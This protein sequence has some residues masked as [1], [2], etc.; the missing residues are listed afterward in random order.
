MKKTSFIFTAFMMALLLGACGGKKQAP[1]ADSAYDDWEE[2][3]IQ[4]RDSTVYGL[5]MD[6]S[7]MHSLQLLS[8]TGDTLMLDVMQAQENG[9]VYGGYSVGDRMAVLLNSDRSQAIM[10]LNLNALMGDWVMQNPF[11]GSSETGISIRDGG[12]A[13]SI[14]PNS[15]M[16]Q[17]W[18]LVNGMLELSGVREGSNDFEETELYQI[19]LL[20]SDSLVFSNAEE[21]F[22]YSHP[23]KAEDYSDIELEDEGFNDMVF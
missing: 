7:A 15:L 16:Y 19:Q 14:N 21:I 17:T 6:G 4:N 18:R 3:V 8:D 11:D 22:E 12:F 2:Q 5:C 1:A 10:V 13:E 9:K 20:T 23:G